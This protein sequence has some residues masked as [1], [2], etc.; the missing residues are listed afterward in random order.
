M[1]GQIASGF[2]EPDVVVVGAGP[3]GLVAS[4]SLASAGVAVLL[5]E[6]RDTLNT[7]SRASTIHPPTLE[8]L[9][10]LG[11]LALVRQEGQVVDR[12]Q[13]RTPD[14]VFAQ[15]RLADLAGETRFPFR[16]HLEQARIT[17]ALLAALQA[18]PNAQ[19]RFG[20]EV[21]GLAQDEAG[22]AL[23]LA[24]GGTIRAKLVLAGDGAHSTVRE[25]AGIGFDGVAYPGKVLRLMT[26]D[27]LDLLL[28]DIAPITYLF[29][30][31][32]SLSFLKMPD[33]WRII[34]RVPGALADEEAMAEGWM[35]ERIREVL[36]RC[37][38]LPGVLKRDVYRASRAVAEDY[39][40]GRVFLMGDAAHVTNT[41]GG[42]NMNCGIADAVAL[43]RAIVAGQG[44]PD[45]VGA[46]AAERRRVAVEQLIPR[47]DRSVSNGEA[48]SET[49]R[50]TAADPEAAIAYLRTA[51]ML[52]ML[53]RIPVHA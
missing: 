20:A 18:R 41:R 12:I 22:V 39:R 49:I 29:N 42:M 46:A 21:V 47:T 44:D 32:H 35:L 28:P 8:I 4:L 51:C 19:V 10:H 16:M 13:Y 17:P 24:G 31:P 36:P 14:H 48:W 34:I 9:D 30:G 50:R 45:I 53:D 52:D 15:F 38:R 23:R 43:S 5:L 1:E 11:V 40:A 33:C 27:D 3:V 37:D 2:S 7:A 6:K 26:G 25:A